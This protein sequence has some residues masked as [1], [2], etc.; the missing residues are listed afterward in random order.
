MRTYV[1]RTDPDI[2]FPSPRS[3]FFK[4]EEAAAIRAEIV[5]GSPGADCSGLGICR[6]MGATPVGIRYKCPVV[7]AWL[8]L[9]QERRLRVHFWKD[10]MDLRFMRRHFRWCL[11]QVLE[12]YRI[13]DELCRA[14]PGV[15]DQ[16]IRPGIYTVWETPEYLVVD[17]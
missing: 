6:M 2:H 8:S 10:S 7:S 16:T 9:T 13:P 3:V 17:F 11:F 15:S 14:L 1:L 12:P 5:L 4:Q